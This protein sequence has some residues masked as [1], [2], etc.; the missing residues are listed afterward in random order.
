MLIAF[1][2]F[3]NVNAQNT[4]WNKYKLQINNNNSVNK[5]QAL[6]YVK[7]SC[8][9][10]QGTIGGTVNIVCDLPF[11]GKNPICFAANI[12]SVS[13]DATGL[14]ES[15][16]LGSNNEA[17]T[18]LAYTIIS[19]II[20]RFG[21]WEVKIV[22]NSVDKAKNLWDAFSKNNVPDQIDPNHPINNN[23]IIPNKKITSFD[24]S[25][26][27]SSLTVFITIYDHNSIQDDYYDL[28]VNGVFLGSVKNPTGGKVTYK[29][30]LEQGEN[31]IELR[32][33]KTMGK[34]TLLKINVSPGNFEQEFSGSRNHNYLIYAP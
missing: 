34:N 10:Y 5:Y 8:N 26:K 13:C 29:A 9:L 28:F 22:V 15:F 31:T 4:D 16:V 17:I 32:L 19:R 7:K 11:I 6:V 12:V 1:S 24:G 20:K 2:I 33:T 25:G 18:E 3:L 21:G 23:D 27:V 30:F 14:V